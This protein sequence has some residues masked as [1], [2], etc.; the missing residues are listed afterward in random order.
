MTTPTADR[1]SFWLTRDGAFKVYPEFV[2]GIPQITVYSW[3]E[4]MGEAGDWVPVIVLHSSEEL[5]RH[6]PDG[7]LHE[8]EVPDFPPDEG[9]PA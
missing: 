7:S 9:V 2:E 6:F 1:E 4:T 8:F 3:S 5:S